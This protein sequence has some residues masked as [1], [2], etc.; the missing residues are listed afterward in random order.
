[1]KRIPLVSSGEYPGI[2]LRKNP[3]DEFF[4][5]LVEWKE[6]DRLLSTVGLGPSTMKGKKSVASVLVR[7]GKE[8]I[9]KELLKERGKA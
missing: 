3:V 5:F 2:S 6:T 8:V 9:Q 4:D 7:N 1:M